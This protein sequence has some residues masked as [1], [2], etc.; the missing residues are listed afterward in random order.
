[1]KAQKI[2][3]LEYDFS[4]HDYLQG[5]CPKC[6]EYTTLGESCCGHGAIIEGALCSDDEAESMVADRTPVDQGGAAE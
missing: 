1:M 3:K 4:Q 5:M 2:V 6:Y